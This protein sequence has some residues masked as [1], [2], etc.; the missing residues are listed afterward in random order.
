MTTVSLAVGSVFAL[1]GAG[2]LFV[3]GRRLVNGVRIW[4]SDPV[5]VREVAQATGADEFE[6]VVRGRERFRAPFTGVAAVLSTYTVERRDHDDDGG[7][8]DTVADGTLRRQFAVEDETGLVVVDPT[9]AEIA[10][11]NESVRTTT[12]DRLSEGVRLRLSTLTDELP[13]G[14]VL[15]QEHSRK[16]RYSE[17]YIAP[18]DEVH[19]YGTTVEKRTPGDPSVDAHVTGESEDGP[20]RITAGGESAAVGGLL[21]GG[22]LV[23]GI[24]AVLLAVSL[25]LL[26]TAFP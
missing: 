4:R 7:N 2:L 26:V 23:G 5:P 16:R 3:G 18:G 11:Q 10:P 24:G 1:V 6:G 13:L 8:W 22:L 25:L 14:D 17:G 9:D 15:A 20:Y 12:A 21:R 19:V